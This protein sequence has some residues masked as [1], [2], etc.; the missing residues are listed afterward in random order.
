MKEAMDTVKYFNNAWEV[1]MQ[2]ISSV[3]RAGMTERLT[4]G[5][6]GRQNEEATAF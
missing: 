1:V 5:Y 2:I 6:V 3:V 4:A